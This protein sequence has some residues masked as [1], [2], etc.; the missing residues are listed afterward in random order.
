MTAATRET[1]TSRVRRA[2]ATVTDPE[3]DEPITELGFVAGIEVRLREDRGHEVSVRLRLP[4]S[5]CA[6]NFACLMVADAHDAVLALP[7]VDAVDIVLEDHFAAEEIN[8]GVAASAGFGGVFP[9][10]AGGELTE[11]RETFRRKAH[12]A[13]L[14]LAVR[15]LVEQGWQVDALGA[16]SLG[17]VPDSPERRSLLRRRA[18]L[19]LPTDP[20]APLLVGDDGGP[21]TAD[22]V[23]TRLRFAKAVRVGIE[24]N[25]G[26]C[27]GLLHTRYPRRAEEVEP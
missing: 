4:T 20:A 18:D 16:G 25:A 21:V 8:A 2:L 11:L 13:C 5:F 3:L 9:G 12:L 26:L 23:A 7:S 10:Q 22:R 19:G 6:P 14:E 1:L 15:K 17:D 27:R 24:G